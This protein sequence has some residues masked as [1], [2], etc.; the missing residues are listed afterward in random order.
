MEMGEVY[1]FQK[2]PLKNSV[3]VGNKSGQCYISRK[4]FPKLSLV[5]HWSFKHHFTQ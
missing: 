1:T 5:S 4:T 3:R 2:T